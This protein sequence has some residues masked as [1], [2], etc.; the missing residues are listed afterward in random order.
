MRVLWCVLAVCVLA[1]AAPLP[2]F[3][4]VLV[5]DLGYAAL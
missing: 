2:N 4:F 5:D 3:L 1:S